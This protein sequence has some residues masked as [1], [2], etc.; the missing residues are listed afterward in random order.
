MLKTHRNSDKIQ[1]VLIPGKWPTCKHIW[2]VWQYHR[3]GRLST[4]FVRVDIIGG[5]ESMSVTTQ[6]YT[7]QSRKDTA[8][9][10]SLIKPPTSL[11]TFMYWDGLPRLRLKTRWPHFSSKYQALFWDQNVPPWILELCIERGLKKSC[12]IKY[13]FWTQNG[14]LVMVVKNITCVR[15]KATLNTVT[16][17]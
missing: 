10:T 17:Y 5:M 13:R 11:A 14:K 6:I 3:H 1:H 8:I 9:S 12:M 15:L 16:R 4:R 2:R 7:V